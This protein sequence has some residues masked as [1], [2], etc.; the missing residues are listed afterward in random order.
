MNP[1]RFRRTIQEQER[2]NVTYLATCACGEGPILTAMMAARGLGAN[3]AALLKY[4]N[5]GDT[6]C[7]DR[8]QVVGYGAVA[9]WQAPAVP[10]STSSGLCLGIGG[11]RTGFATKG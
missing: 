3:Q 5:S 6:P 11:A 10:S 1:E 9:F 2:R 4:A 7:G 8:D